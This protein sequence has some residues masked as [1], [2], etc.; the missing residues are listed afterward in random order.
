MPIE[1]LRTLLGQDISDADSI[2]LC[3]DVAI[4]LQA[5]ADPEGVAARVRAAVLPL[6]PA[7]S[8]PEVLT[9]QQQNNVFLDA[10]EHEPP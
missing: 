1:A 10:V 3:S 9:W 2:A 6:L 7:G 4:K 8:A 5:G